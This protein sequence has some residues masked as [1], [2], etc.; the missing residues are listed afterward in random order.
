MDQHSPVRFGTGHSRPTLRC[1]RTLLLTLLVPNWCTERQEVSDVHLA[2]ERASHSRCHDY[3]LGSCTCVCVYCVCVCIYQE[4]AKHVERDEV[5][6]REA[7]AAELSRVVRMRITDG[8]RI[9]GHGHHD[10]LPR[11]TCSRPIPTHTNARTLR[12]QLRSRRVRCV[13]LR[14]RAVTRDTASSDANAAEV[15]V[16]QLTRL[17]RIEML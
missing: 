12:P 10:F 17:G 3:A 1:N 14:R 4:R 5:R 7:A 6:E 13:A 2:T 16:T 9:V 15:T 11:L 8:H